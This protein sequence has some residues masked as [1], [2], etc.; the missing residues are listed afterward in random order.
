M[1]GNQVNIFL[2]FTKQILNEPFT[3]TTGKLLSYVMFSVMQLSTYDGAISNN[4]F[5]YSLLN[6]SNIVS[7]SVYIVSYSIIRQ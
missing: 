2:F 6:M 7:S 3:N 4:L 5:N 1:N